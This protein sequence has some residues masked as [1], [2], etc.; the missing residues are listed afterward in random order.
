MKS[1][2][3]NQKSDD[4]ILNDYEIV[5][6]FKR[7]NILKERIE[8]YRDFTINLLYYIFDTYL[9]KE[10]IHKDSDVIGHFNWCYTK[11]LD[12][13]IE[14]EIDFYNNKNI[15]DYFFNFYYDQL[16]S[17]DNPKPLNYFILLWDEIFNYKKDKKKKHFDVLLEIYN[18]F[19][20]SIEK[21]KGNLELV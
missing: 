2:I 5:R 15:Y 1:L 18:V 11:V 16:Y 13:F 10:Y 12:E 14:E 20:P 4:D 9:G 7:H 19:N 17:A 21:I 3:Q 8:I 6:E